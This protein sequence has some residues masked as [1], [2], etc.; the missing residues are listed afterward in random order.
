MLTCGVAFQLRSAKGYLSALRKFWLH[1]QFPGRVGNLGNQDSGAAASAAGLM[2]RQSSTRRVGDVIYFLRSAHT[3]VKHPSAFFLWFVFS[4]TCTAGLVHAEN[5]PAPDPERPLWLRHP[6]VSPDGNSIAFAYGGQIWKVAS[7]G[8]EAVA[9]TSGDFY[10]TRPVWAPDGKTLAFASK[11]HGNFDVFTMPSAGGTIK[12]L[13]EHSA[14]DLPYAFSPDG[15]QIYFSSSRLGDTNTVRVGAYEGSDQLYTVPTAGGSSRLLLPTP[16]LDVSVSADGMQLLYDNRPVYENEFRKGGVSDGTRDIWLYDR[17]TQKHRQITTH[18]G[19]DRDA[20]WAP[21]GKGFYFLSERGGSFNVWQQS[22]AEGAQAKQITEHRGQP[23]R[24]L[25]VANNG[26]LVY[27]FEG[28]IWRR[29]PGDVQSSRV[30]VHIS[31]GSLVAGTFPSSANAYV[32]EIAVSPDGSEVATVARGEVFVTSMQSGRTRRITSTPAFEHDVSFSPD[33]RTLLYA[34][35]RDG[36]SDIFEASVPADRPAAFTAAGPVVEKKVINT[37]GDALYP[38]YSPD[39][40]SIAYL[41]NRQSIKVL[42]RAT[43]KTVTAL[44][45]GQIYSYQD[46]DM[47]MKWSPDG[48]WIVATTGSLVGFM[49]IKL[50]DASG[51]FEPVN[52]SQSGFQDCAPIFTPDSKAVI[53]ESDRNALRNADSTGGQSDVYIVHL[54]QEAYDVFNEARNGLKPA[55]KPTTQMDNNWQPQ[56]RGLRHRM[57]R[58]TPYSLISIQFKQVQPDGEGLILVTAEEPGVLVGYR[59]NLYTR[60]LDKVF[61]RPLS[62]AIVSADAKGETLYSAEPATID[63]INLAKGSSTPTPYTA[64]IDYD[65]RGEVA[66][67][68]QYFWR[69]TKLKFYRPDMHGRDWNALRTTYARYLPHMHEWEDFADL[70]GEMAGELNASH[71]AGIYLH[72]AALSDNTASLGIY[73]DP[74][75]TGVGVRVASVLKGGPADSAKTL[76]RPGAVILAIDGQAITGN[77]QYYALLNCKAGV[78][79]EISVQV[80][81]GAQP[82]PQT[83]TPVALTQELELAYDHWVDRRKALTTELSKGRLG[84]VHIDAMDSENYQ[85]TVDQVFG[86]SRDKEGLIVDVRFNK[87]GLLHDQLAALFTGQVVGSFISRDGVNRGSIPMNRWTKPTAL[88]ANATSYSDGSIFPHVYQRMGIGPVIGD[89]V[90]GTGTAVW[91]IYVLK[92]IKYGIPQLGANDLKS[93]WFENDEIVPNVLVYNDPDVI[94]AGRD[95]Q[96]EAA[97]QE[98]LK[99]K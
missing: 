71:M 78:P 41:D 3:M 74:A 75:H 58:L 54:T 53:W 94:A 25:S 34:S 40:K 37:E 81:P 27:G 73:E 2:F 57:T 14:N 66:Y 7:T 47:T 76:L 63:R 98:L 50:L 56:V 6:A 30:P 38:A 32:S 19:E 61:S 36:D 29:N 8:G 20:F 90:P 97:V 95:V 64:K 96:L 77:E 31:Q 88:L 87:G 17:S 86:E 84:Y 89:R 44:K 28:E 43:G 1:R 82:A 80:T 51:N 69:M 70:L 83:I 72:Q 68:F 18:R 26:T 92:L 99:A 16:A 48:R 42:D 49:D 45:E 22:L 9:L 55:A 52:L 13:T 23:V 67:L 39:G 79:V 10:S 65:P 35:E 15:Q 4:I 59:L 24:F 62:N 33:G 91:W 85:R 21:D 60:T 5:L 46:G 11:R 93:G 12:R